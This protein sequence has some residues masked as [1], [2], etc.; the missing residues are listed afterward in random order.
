MYVEGEEM[1][2]SIKWN[3]SMGDVSSGWDTELLLEKGGSVHGAWCMSK[4][5][6]SLER[7]VLIP[8][9]RYH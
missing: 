2:D 6:G 3:R 8:T 7:L 9:T 4:G 1:M 5:R